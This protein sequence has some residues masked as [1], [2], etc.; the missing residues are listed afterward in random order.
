MR[1]TEA[2]KCKKNQ[3]DFYVMVQIDL[4]KNKSENGTLLEKFHL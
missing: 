3:G 1:K 4:K 2:F